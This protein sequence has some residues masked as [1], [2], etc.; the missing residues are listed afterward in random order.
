MDYSEY[1]G[2]EYEKKREVMLKFLKGDKARTT[3]LMDVDIEQYLLN[4]YGDWTW[5]IRD[6]APRKTSVRVR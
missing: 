2:E 6:R 4:E 1:I 5:G 3:E